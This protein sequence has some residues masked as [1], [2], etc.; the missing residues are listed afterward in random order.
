MTHV[1][2][3]KQTVI[4]EKVTHIYVMMLGDEEMISN[5]EL[6]EFFGFLLARSLF[7]IILNASYCE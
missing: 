1:K 2:V 7:Q 3:N 5:A 6:G 4:N